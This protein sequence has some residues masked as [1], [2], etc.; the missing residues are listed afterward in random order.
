ML[1]KQVF[2]VPV[3]PAQRWVLLNVSHG[4][5]QKLSGKDGKSYRRFMR[6]FGLTKIRETLRANK[7][8]GVSSAKV[9]SDEPELFELTEENLEYVLTMVDKTARKPAE[10]D[11]I[12]DLLDLLEDIKAGREYQ[13]PAEVAQYDA[14]ADDWSPPPP[15]GDKGD[16]DAEG[17]A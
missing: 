3:T 15:T 12:G 4:D 14:T 10:E 5:E 6:A 7:D 11:V 8:T 9:N 17:A 13:P 1:N 16:D 2:L